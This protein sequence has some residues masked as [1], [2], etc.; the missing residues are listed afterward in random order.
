MVEFMIALEV[1]G[2]GETHTP[3]PAA[4]WSEWRNPSVWPISCVMRPLKVAWFVLKLLPTTTSTS[5]VLKY[6][7]PSLRV[8]CPTPLLIPP[9]AATPEGTWFDGSLKRTALIPSAD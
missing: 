5:A 9:M 6:V 4:F 8:Y 1:Q 7:K 2:D 3:F